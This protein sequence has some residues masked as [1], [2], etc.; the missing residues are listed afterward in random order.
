MLYRITRK[1][2][3]GD[4]SITASILTAIEQL[5]L[6]ALFEIAGRGVV[7]NTV[8]ATL[9]ALC[10]GAV[11]A[12]PPITL[13]CVGAVIGWKDWTIDN[14]SQRDQRLS[15]TIDLDK[16]RASVDGN[17]GCTL[18]VVELLRC[19]SL[20]EPVTVV[21]DRVAYSDDASNDV[22]TSSASFII[23][24]ISGVMRTTSSLTNKRPDR[25]WENMTFDGEFQCEVKRRQF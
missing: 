1:M 9:L 23:N 2:L 11:L 20:P 10:G 14:K 7:G 3:E 6:L 22:Y 13:S 19:A 5:H 4:G 8:V 16:Q 21:E 17:W 12:E 24:R 18:I 15:V 25:S